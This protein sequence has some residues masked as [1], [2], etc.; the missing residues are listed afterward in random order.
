M[1]FNLRNLTYILITSLMSLVLLNSCEEAVITKLPNKSENTVVP[2]PPIPPA[3]EVDE[4]SINTTKATK[5]VVKFYEGHLHGAD[6]YHYVA[7][8]VVPSPYIRFEQ[9]LVYKFVNN[10]WVLQE[11]TAY[12]TEIKKVTD[13]DDD[14]YEELV[15]VPN[16]LSVDKLV[17]YSA[18]YYE[19][20]GEK[21]PKPVYGIWIEYYDA[22]DNIINEEFAKP[23][24]YQHFFIPRNIKAI[25][26]ITSNTDNSRNQVYKF[27]Y[28]DTSEWNKTNSEHK[29]PFRGKDDPV[30]LKGFFIFNSTGVSM[31][32]DLEL[33]ETGS[34]S[35][36]VNGVAD[37]VYAPSERITKGRKPAIRL[38]IL[39]YIPCKISDLEN[40]YIKGADNLNEE[41]TKLGNSIVKLLNLQSIKALVDN[42]TYRIEGDRGDEAGGVWF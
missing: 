17:A 1:K 38:R 4:I 39:L 14:E 29:V 33:W 20:Y 42:L 19:T 13:E 34:V 5:I 21:S 7:G 9:E 32:F 12:G 31:D 35:K 16:K 41:Q 3:E 23:G 2:T 37:P 8:S 40:F 10:E 25:D 11:N 36:A 30:G 6:N 24:A 26:G 28:R 15:K 18:H 27:T 22:N